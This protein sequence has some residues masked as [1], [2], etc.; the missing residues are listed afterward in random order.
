[1]DGSQGQSKIQSSIAS[2]NQWPCHLTRDFS[3]LLTGMNS[4]S[5]SLSSIVPNTITT[6]IDL[7]DASIAAFW[8][9]RGHLQESSQL[10]TSNYPEILHSIF[11]SRVWGWIKGWFDERMRNK[12][13]VLGKDPGPRLREMTGENLN[14][15]SECSSPGPTTREARGVRT[16][17]PRNCGLCK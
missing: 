9:L 8:R 10:A 14:G 1:M 5:A 6:I 7:Q 16:P 4:G 2:L 15:S 17:S 11:F 3:E 13:F 12:I